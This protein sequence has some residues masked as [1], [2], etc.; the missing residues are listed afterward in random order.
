MCLSVIALVSVFRMVLDPQ[1]ADLLCA[2]SVQHLHLSLEQLPVGLIVVDQN[3]A[4]LSTDEW[5][6]QLLGFCSKNVKGRSIT[7]IFGD[8]SHDW[9]NALS[10]HENSYFGCLPL[11][12]KSG[13]RLK[14]D[15]AA[16]PSLVPHRSELHI[17]FTLDV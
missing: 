16:A 17:V 3:A 9:I 8:I 1:V 6:E 5:S 12:T 10:K 11:T 13:V 14:I 2:A 7:S 15:V 4:I